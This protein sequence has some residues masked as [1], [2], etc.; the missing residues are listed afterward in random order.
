M[1]KAKKSTG[2]QA[3][4]ERPHQHD[5]DLDPWAVAR[6]ARVLGVD[7][8]TLVKRIAEAKL[9]AAKKTAYAVY[10]YPRDIV[11]ML[12]A[13]R[14]GAKADAELKGAEARYKEARAKQAEL[15]LKAYERVLVPADEVVRALSDLLVAVRRKVLA[16][17]SKV[18]PRM[19]KAKTPEVALALLKTELSQ[20][21]EDLSKT[22]P[23][24]LLAGGVPAAGDDDE[25]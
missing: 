8:T 4:S 12:L 15:K 7:R 16:I 1:P 23:S 11:A 21:L 3:P 17:P 6:I 5:G 14:E 25:A 24:E 10:Y 22:D 13:T 19:V 18:A 2:K 20:A 9:E